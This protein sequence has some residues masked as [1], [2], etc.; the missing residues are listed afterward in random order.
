VFHDKR[1]DADGRPGAS[2]FEH[3]SGVL[4]R[5]FL[6]HRYARPDV[7]VATLQWVDAAGEASHRRAVET[8]RRREADH[9]LPE[10]IPGAHTVADLDSDYY[11][12]SRFAY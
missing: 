10:A 1:L 8:Y 5:L 11:G 4:A 9:D 6:A 7:V 12:P 2:D 3:E